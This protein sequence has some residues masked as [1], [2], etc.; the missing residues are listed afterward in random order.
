[1]SKASVVAAARRVR[2]FTR[3][4]T[5]VLM[6]GLCLP[7]S[8]DRTTAGYGSL[9]MPA[10]HALRRRRGDVSTSTLEWTIV[11]LNRL[12]KVPASP[13]PLAKARPISRTDVAA[14]LLDLVQDAVAA[15][16]AVN[17]GRG[18]RGEANGSASAH[19]RIQ[20]KDA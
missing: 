12:T 10:R 5:A 18:F 15:R 1:M 2:G 13:D 19:G 11:R 14:T 4:P 8:R 6:L 16:I 9:A 17:V 7:H 20:H 3:S